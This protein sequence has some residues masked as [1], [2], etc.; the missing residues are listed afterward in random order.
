MLSSR[1]TPLATGQ[2][3][4]ECVFSYRLCIHRPC[5]STRQRTVHAISCSVM[6]F[7]YLL[8][9]SFMIR[10]NPVHPLRRALPYP[11][12]MRRCVCYNRCL[13]C[14]SALVYRLALRN[15]I[16]QYCMVFVPLSVSRWN[17]LNDLLFDKVVLADCKCR[18]IFFFA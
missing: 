6:Q 10:S 3:S 1:F 12:C 13:G 2:S 17:D 11:Y 15:K 5:S 8:C 14:L 18:A 16:F 4:Q 7:P 9:I